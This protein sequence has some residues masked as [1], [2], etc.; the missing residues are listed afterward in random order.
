MPLRRRRGF[1]NLFLKAGGRCRLRLSRRF[2]VDIHSLDAREGGAE[3]ELEL[4]GD[5]VHP[6]DGEVAVHRAVQADQDA[7]THTACGNGVAVVNPFALPGDFENLAFDLRQLLQGFP[8]GFHDPGPWFDVDRHV[9]DG[10]NLIEHR[11][12]QARGLSMRALER[13]G[14]FHFQ[15]EVHVDGSPIE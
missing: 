10:G 2:G 1:G 5:V 7:V 13:E 4:F 8:A 6:G 12:F 11:L 3:A 15:V 9:A 14:R